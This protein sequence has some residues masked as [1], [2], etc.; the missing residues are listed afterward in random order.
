MGEAWGDFFEGVDSEGGAEGGEVDCSERGGGD[1][2]ESD[3]LNCV[4]VDWGAEGD[5]DAERIT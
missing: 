3:E 2:R 1:E 5:D 4:G